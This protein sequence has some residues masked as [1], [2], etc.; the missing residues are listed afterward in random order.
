ML[1]DKP[2]L[3]FETNRII[4]LGQEFGAEAGNQIIR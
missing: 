2:F 3:C 4:N 1:N